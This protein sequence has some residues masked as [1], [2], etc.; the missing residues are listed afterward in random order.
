MHRLGRRG[1]TCSR[2]PAGPLPH[3]FRSWQQRLDHYE[4]HQL[5]SYSAWLDYHDALHGRETPA[6]RRARD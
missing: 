4:Q 6:E 3:G 1:R 2:Q 5:D